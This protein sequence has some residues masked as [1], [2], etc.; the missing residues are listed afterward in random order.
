LQHWFSRAWRLR[1]VCRIPLQ[2]TGIKGFRSRDV[3][4]VV[5][6]LMLQWAGN[7]DFAVTLKLLGVIPVPVRISCIAFKLPLRVCL[8]VRAASARARASRK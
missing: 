7:Q 2:V 1:C 4:E 3:E 5:L 6:D 8:G